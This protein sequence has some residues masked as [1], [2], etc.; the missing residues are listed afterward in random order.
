MISN[1]I[2]HS[3][4]VSNGNGDWAWLCT[5]KGISYVNLGENSDDEKPEH[6]NFS[7]ASCCLYDSA[8]RSEITILKHHEYLSQ[9]LISR[10]YKFTY[11]DSFSYYSSRAPP[12]VFS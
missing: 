4:V 3:K 11:S 5:S 9:T 6:N 2:L 7:S 10:P 12:V 1:P 8:P